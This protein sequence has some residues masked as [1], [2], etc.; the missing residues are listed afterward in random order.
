MGFGRYITRFKQYL[1]GETG[2]GLPG[3]FYEKVV[4]DI[5]LKF[6]LH[7][8]SKIAKK[9]VKRRFGTNLRHKGL[10]K[11]RKILLKHLRSADLK[12][13]DALET[14]IYFAYAIADVDVP[15][16]QDYQSVIRCIQKKFPN[17]SRED[18]YIHDLKP[19]VEVRHGAERVNPENIREALHD[20]SVLKSFSSSDDHDVSPEFEKLIENRFED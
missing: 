15:Y 19:G 3:G 9:V 1:K 17:K 10:S 18:I 4:V 5:F 13:H 14:F 6:F 11:E 2:S 8:F 20:S 12:Y 16:Y 7:I